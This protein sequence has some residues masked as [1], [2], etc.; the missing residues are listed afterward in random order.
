MGDRPQI[1]IVGGGSTGAGTARDLA[2]RGL[3]VT[4][5][6]R[7][8][9]ASGATGRMHG[10][11]HSGAR[12]ADTDPESAQ[13]CIEENRVLREIAGHCL[14]DTGGLFVQHPADPPEYIERKQ[15]ACEE[16]SIPVERLDGDQARER[17]PELAEEVTSALAVPDA[18]VD[19]CRLMAATALSAERHGADIETNTRTDD[20]VRSDGTVERVRLESGGEART[21]TVDHVVNATGPWT[22]SVAAMAD[23]D[24]PVR[25]SKGALAVLDTD[26]VGTV[27]NR[28]RPRGEGDIAVPHPGGTILG[29]TD[30]DVDDPD[31]FEESAAELELLVEELTPVL[32]AVGEATVADAYWGVR[33]LFDP[34]G[35]DAT[36]SVS[37]GFEIID[38]ERRDGLAGFTT[39]IG[40]KF[41]THRLIAER[42]A[43][44][45]CETVGVDAPCLTA[46]EQLPGHVDD[47]ID[48]GVLDRFDVAPPMRRWSV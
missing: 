27:V 31:T 46:G 24:V 4:L 26:A 16:C 48:E 40:G 5:I 7:D 2:M 36:A 43:D 10:L 19:P 47:P 35:E 8:G 14:S 42:V 6:E 28:C 15:T 41:T 3:D 39:V 34:A 33:P 18:A 11:L 30:I 25:Q 32:P 23:V 21:T 9:L 13:T 37:R 12:Y 44:H 29:A 22:D 38:H 17:E 1:L 45:V 20:V